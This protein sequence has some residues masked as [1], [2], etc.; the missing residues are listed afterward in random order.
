[1]E[2]QLFEVD[3]LT[4]SS[5]FLDLL[6]YVMLPYV[7]GEIEGICSFLERACPSP[8]L[9]CRTYLPSVIRLTAIYILLRHGVM[10]LDP[11]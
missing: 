6:L 8:T 2:S 10:L 11:L 9:F 5:K 3:I 4:P 7:G 1:M